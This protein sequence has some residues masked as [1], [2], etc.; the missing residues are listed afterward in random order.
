MINKSRNVYAY[1][2]IDVTG[3]I[4]DVVMDELNAVDGVI[5]IRVID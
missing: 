3:D 5:R 1:T 2:I 4:T